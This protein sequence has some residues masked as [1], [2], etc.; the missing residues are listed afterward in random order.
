VRGVITAR[1]VK[2]HASADVEGD[3][4]H[5]ELVIEAGARFNGR[6]VRKEPQPAPAL[7]VVGAE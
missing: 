1:A 6:S 7:T 5:D 4:A 3:I 2:L